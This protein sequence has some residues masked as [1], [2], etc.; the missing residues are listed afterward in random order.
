MYN[1]FQIK[2]YQTLVNFL[3][4]QIIFTVKLKVIILKS[5]Q[6]QTDPKSCK[7]SNTLIHYFKIVILVHK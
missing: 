5:Q 7:T 2:L 3:V 4:Q 6:P 1:H